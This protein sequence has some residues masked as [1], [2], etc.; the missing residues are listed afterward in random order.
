MNYAEIFGALSGFLY[1]VLEIK[2]N[3]YMWIVGGISALV[4]TIIFLNSALFA[5]MGL[6]MWYVGA[7]LYGWIMWRRQSKSVGS[8]EPMIMRLSRRKVVNS[9]VIALL[10]FFLLWYILENF[11]SDPM[12]C[13]DA[14]MASLS[15]L[16]TYWVA[17]RF[18]QHWILWIVVDLLAAYIYL[19]QGLYATVVLYI[20]FTVSAIVGF[21]EWRKYKEV[22]D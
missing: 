14:L 7:S 20:V 13:L 17:N 10:G 8:E 4:Y 1:V 19:S 5:S 3:K 18:I 11:S 16:A 9:T 22:L 12:P 21:F 15:M 6:Q 2:Q